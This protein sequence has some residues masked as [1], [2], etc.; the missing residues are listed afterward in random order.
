MSQK[1]FKDRY[2]T[3]SKVAEKFGVSSMTV[4]RWERNPKLQFPKAV[5]INNRSYFAENILDRW[6]LHRA[7]RTDAT[8]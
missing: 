4:Y 1:E 2:L 5:I 8:A 3:R 7:V 6:A